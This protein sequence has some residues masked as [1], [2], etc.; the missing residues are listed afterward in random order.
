[1]RVLA[2]DPGT[3]ETAYVVYE[4]YHHDTDGGRIVEHG[5][6]PNLDMLSIIAT[7][8]ADV[9]AMEMIGHYN[10]GM[11]VGADVF[12][13]CVWIGRFWQQAQEAG[14]KKVEILF[15]T[16]IKIELCGSPRAN[17]TN[18]SQALKDILGLPG[19]KKNP[20][21]TYGITSHKWQALA[22]AL[23]SARGLGHETFPLTK[24]QQ[25]RQDL[26]ENAAQD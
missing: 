12:Q 20:G 15:R 3:R 10:T 25:A 16:P 26:L 17:D 11:S 9:M 4:Y 2:M 18:V 13:T 21:P 23:C 1:M 6:F 22:V 14:V 19:T 5:H 8:P 7:T 24:K